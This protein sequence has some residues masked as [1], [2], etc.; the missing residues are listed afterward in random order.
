MP[1]CGPKI[2]AAGGHRVCPPKPNQ[3]SPMGS[4]SHGQQHP[5]PQGDVVLPLRCMQRWGGDI[6]RRRFSAASPRAALPSPPG[7]DAGAISPS[8]ASQLLTQVVGSRAHQAVQGTQRCPA[9]PTSSWVQ[10]LRGH[11]GRP[12][13]AARPTH[14]PPACGICSRLSEPRHSA[15][16]TEPD[17][18]NGLGA[19]PELCRG[20]WGRVFAAG[21]ICLGR[22]LLVCLLEPLAPTPRCS[23]SCPLHTTTGSLARHRVPPGSAA[24]ALQQPAAAPHKGLEG[25]AGAA[26]G[27]GGCSRPWGE[28]KAERLQLGDTVRAFATR[29]LQGP[30]A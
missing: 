17:P 14:A 1:Q 4:P 8:L 5:Q 29:T 23:P 27:A 3:P 13:A 26:G 22:T 25:R 11:T 9:V 12:R 21:N 19:P 20:L 6:S 30:K 2:T 28:S 18:I 16:F 15:A 10:G 24:P 7:R